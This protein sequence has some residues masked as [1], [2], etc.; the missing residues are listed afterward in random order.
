MKSMIETIFS[1]KERNQLSIAFSHLTS[2]PHLSLDFQFFH[3]RLPKHNHPGQKLVR[4]EIQT[5][6]CKK[7][8]R[9]HLPLLFR[10]HIYRKAKKKLYLPTFILNKVCLLIIGMKFAKPYLMV[11]FHFIC[12]NMLHLYV[13]YYI[14]YMKH[15][16][17][18]KMGDFCYLFFLLPPQIRCSIQTHHHLKT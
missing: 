12:Y 9:Y 18:A 1:M 15:K 7:H 13:E 4:I 10:G 5:T 14:K 16:M 6:K 2:F 17:Y 3:V 11:V 8:Q